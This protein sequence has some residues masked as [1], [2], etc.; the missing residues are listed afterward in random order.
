[1][2]GEREVASGLRFVREGR[3][4][5]EHRRAHEKRKKKGGG[6]KGSWGRGDV[7]PP[8]SL[9][10]N[11]SFSKMTPSLSHTGSWRARSKNFGALFNGAPGNNWG[12]G[13]A[14]TQKNLAESCTPAH[15]PPPPCF[16]FV[17][18]HPPFFFGA[19]HVSQ[20]V[21][22]GKRVE[23][24]DGGE[25][26]ARAPRCLF[27][28]PRNGIE[29]QIC[30][31]VLAFSWCLAASVRFSAELLDPQQ[32]PKIHGGLFRETRFPALWV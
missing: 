7:K 11:F 3:R 14:E 19:F 23:E 16:P 5:R 18:P 4:R 12:G 13:L 1:M 21:T 9:A 10:P 31:L 27:P 29:N 30:N 25:R 22:P 8:V 28:C 17:F 20:A 2:G 6:V 24:G 15:A 26:H 32:F